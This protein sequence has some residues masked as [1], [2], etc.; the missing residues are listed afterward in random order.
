MVAFEINYSLWGNRQL[1]R[2]AFHYVYNFSKE[3]SVWFEVASGMIIGSTGGP[4]V[5]AD[6]VPAVYRGPKKN[7]FGK[8]K[9]W[10]V[11]K[12]QNAR[13]ARTGCNMVK[14]SSPNAPSTWLIF[15]CPRTHASPQTCRHSASSVL[16]VRISF[17]VI[18]VFVFRKQQEEW[19]SR[20]PP[21]I[22]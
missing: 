8:L 22:G 6:S 20:W 3:S 12:F 21:T 7:F 19:R 5:S 10:K 1:A 9:K 13:Q 16:A 17:R 18:A 14:S 4:P 11:H 2:S 15:L